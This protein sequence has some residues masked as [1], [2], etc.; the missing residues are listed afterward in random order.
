MGS[1]GCAAGGCIT[2]GDGGCASACDAR[3]ESIPST[4]VC[5]SVSWPI[6]ADAGCAAAGGDCGAASGAA[7]AEVGRGG[8]GSLMRRRVWHVARTQRKSL[9]SGKMLGRSAVTPA[10]FLRAIREAHALAGAAASLAIARLAPTHE[11]EPVARTG[12]DAV[13]GRAIRAWLTAT[14]GERLPLP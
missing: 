5:G 12:R 6:G 8:D 2:G 1:A 7:G 10:Q 3:R 9:S 13:E 11:R 14:V 4:A